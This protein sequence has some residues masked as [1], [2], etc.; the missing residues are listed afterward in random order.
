[1]KLYLDPGHGGTDPGAQGNGLNEKDVTLDIALK[2]RTILLN[3]YENIDIKMSRTSDITKGLTERTNE[4]NSWGADYY[5]A[6]HI[7]AGRGTGYEDYI[8]SG[9]S[10]TS[11][12]AKYQD[13]IHAEV[14]KLNSLTDRGQKKA[15]FHVLRESHMP[16]LLSENGFIDNAHDAALM[17]QSSWQQN[18]AQGHANGI[19]KAFNLPKKAV[20]PGTGTLYKVIAGSFQSRE[21][22]DDRVTYLSSKGID[23]F[24]DTV[25][26]SGKIWYRV[27]AGAYGNR[28]NADDRLNE[29]KKAGITDA[30]IIAE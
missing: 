13:I 1:M 17:K 22:A 27:Q 15:N 6:I 14:L 12:S 5:L 20:D 23:S 16:A 19:A 7:N 28:A 21:N 26:I 3:Q 4:A 18:V 24:V 30:F 8:Y 29:L 11:T 2:L 25:T 10:D 9:L